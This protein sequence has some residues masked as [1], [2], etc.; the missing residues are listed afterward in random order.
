MPRNAHRLRLTWLPALTAVLLAGLACNLPQP[1][2]PTPGEEAAATAV[3]ATLTALAGESPA[4]PAP[5][6]ATPPPAPSATATDTPPPTDTPAPTA[7]HTPPPNGVSLNCDGTYQRVRIVD[8]GAAGKTIFVD[9]WQGGGWVN[10]WSLAGG[11]PMLRQITEEAGYYTFGE[12]QKLVVV[13]LRHSNPQVYFE[14]GVYAWDGTTMAQVYYRAGEYGEWEK[15][16]ALIR[17][18]W[19]STLG[20]PD[21]GP[22]GPCEWTTLEHEWNGSAFVQVGSL[23]EQVEGC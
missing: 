15:V 12:C 9:N 10:V 14:L 19:A 4:S 7:T 8:Q 2:S 23:V 1:P 20:Y 13:P 22:L 18:R 3:A 11:D 17:F 16:G 5:P 21:G 6:T